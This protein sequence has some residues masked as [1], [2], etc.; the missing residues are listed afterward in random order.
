MGVIGWLY[1]TA[2]HLRLFEETSN[3][4]VHIERIEP[5]IGDFHRI[6]DH[7]PEEAQGKQICQI[8]DHEKEHVQVYIQEIKIFL[9]FVQLTMNLISRSRIKNKQEILIILAFISGNN[10]KKFIKKIE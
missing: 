7:E 9:E 10:T 5:E 3:K 8:P 4:M 2:R 6:C 1:G